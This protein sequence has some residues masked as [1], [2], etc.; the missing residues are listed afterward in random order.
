MASENSHR[1][2]NAF[3]IFL[4]TAAAFAVV[5][6]VFG[7][8]LASQKPVNEVEQKRAAQRVETRT[9]LDAEAAA[10]LGSLG[11]ADKAKGTAHIPIDQAMTMIVAELT[12][13]K[14]APSSVK[15][16]APLPMPVADPKSA[17]PPPA[18]LP[19]APQGADTVRF[20]LPA[21]EVIPATPAAPAAPAPEKPA[22]APTPAVPATPLVPAAPVPPP[23]P[24]KPAEPAPAPAPVPPAPVPPAPEKPA[25]PA[26]A[27]A[28][29]PPA[30]EPAPAPAPAAPP[31]PTE[32]PEPTK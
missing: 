22:V 1:T 12:A 25:E 4:G 5:A 31:T 17:E 6:L 8:K 11:W 24:E 19:S 13:K 28:P 2:P 30:P 21:A 7:G 10:K 20:P 32:N 15:V 23:A 3:V 9:K 14:P 26:P 18:A 27:P 16:E 29:V